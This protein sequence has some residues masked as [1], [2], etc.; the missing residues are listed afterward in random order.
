MIQLRLR[1]EYSFGETFAPIPR[2]IE[3]LQAI[4][5][6]AAGIVDGS[7]WGHV[8]WASACREAGIQPLLGVEVAVADDE[9][10]TKMWF[11]ANSEAGLR[12]LY[13]ATSKS[14]RQTVPTKRGA[15]PRLYRADVAKLG[16]EITIFAGEVTDGP[17]L[18]EIGAVLDLSPASRVLNAKK[19][20]IAAAHNLRVVAISDNAYAFEEDRTVFELA[21]RGGLKPSPQHILAELDHQEESARIAEAC[22][23]LALPKAPMIHFSGD[24]ERECREGIISRGMQAKW[25]DTYEQRLLY[26]LKLIKDKDYESYFLVVS[27]M[28]RFAKQY[29]LVGPSRGSAAGSLVCYLSRITEIDPLPPGLFFERFIDVTRTDLPDI[30]LDFP[31]DK[32]AMVFEY[33]ADKYGIA[34]VAKIG[35]ISEFRPKSALIQVCKALNIPPTAT[36]AVKVAMIERSSADSRANNCLEDTF[37]LTDPGKQFIAAYPEASKAALLEGHASHSGV[38]AAGL[39]VCN[40]EITNYATV[41]AHGIAH[42]EK[43]AAE[44]LGLLKIDVLGLR[45]L[46]I[47]EDSGIPI[48]WYNLPF[49]DPLVYDVFNQGR[50]CGIFQF[51]GNAL[52]EISRQVRF[53]TLRE[54][55]AVTALARPGPFGGGVT[56][57]YIQR[58]NGKQYAPIHPLV[59][60]HMLDTYGLPVYQEQTLAIVREIGRFDW[61]DTSTIRKVMSKRMGKE[62]F[63]TFWARFKKGAAE[64]GISE[65]DA[66]ATWAMI[67]SSGAWAMNKA[68]TFSYAVISYWT[69][70][71][72]ARHPLEFAAANL[73]SAKNEDSAIQL[74]REMV[75]EGI[76]YKPF[77]LA[78]SEENWSAK[79]GVLVGGFLA[80]KGFG[81]VKARKFV[82]ARDAGILT[83]KQK[84]EVAK[85]LNAFDNIFP[86]QT[87]YGHLYADPRGNDIAADKVFKIGELDGT[88]NDSCVF[89]G[90]LVYKNM[91]NANEGIN[92]K[93]RGGRMETGPLEFIDLCIRDDTGVILARVNRFDYERMG[94]EINEQIPAGAHLMIRARFSEG[95]RFGF[96]QRWKLLA[97]PDKERTRGRARMKAY[98]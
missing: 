41:D 55:D 42:V 38:H 73:R 8:R 65:Q 43:G 60:R 58:M 95:F 80:L 37:S 72:K 5:C 4:G 67:N 28:V 46:G 71:L 12:R 88:Q 22:T 14:H 40:D 20:Q 66:A 19:R 35:T 25:N 64:Q 48:D 15:V 27:D 85:A 92:V 79:D 45:T 21:S 6:R 57:E 34:N 69:A 13:R 30:D 93:K 87:S 76:Q 86:M 33:M 90:E 97:M 70:Y 47:L 83:E 61:K 44:Q 54:I 77:D 1:T 9:L 62:F 63:D 89:L 94:K 84:E 96:I 29:M 16:P 50:M 59:E 23:S 82:A 26:E 24:L 78:L 3:R 31:D 68:H 17:W 91:R 36:A 75:G 53:K 56:E 2:V 74:L 10:P 81:S 49:D 98:A 32:R 39:L 7:T 11:L 52:R 51:E 18:A